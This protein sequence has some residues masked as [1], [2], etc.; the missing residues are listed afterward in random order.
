MARSLASWNADAA[1]D[2]EL[3]EAEL[4]TR[5]L[6]EFV[7]QMWPVV[8]PHRK[9]IDNW[10]IGVICEHLEAVT[11][12]EIK[13]LLIN[14][15]PRH[16]KAIR[17]DEPVWTLN[18]WTPH[19][20]LQP[21]DYVFG[22]D[23][24]PKRVR[25][26]SPAMSD[27]SYRVIF[28]T[29][30]SIVAGAG[31]EWVVERERYDRTTSW[32]RQRFPATVETCG[33]RS[34][35]RCVGQ[36]RPDRIAL[37][38]PVFGPD[39]DLLID[40]YVLGAWLGDGQKR[41]GCIGVAGTDREHFEREFGI[42]SRVQRE[43]TGTYG[44]YH[45]FTV[46]DLSTKLRV[47][48]IHNKESVPHDYLRG[49]VA[50]RLALLQGLMDTD[51]SCAADGQCLFSNTNRALVAAVMDLGYSL[52]FKMHCRESRSR[53]NGVDY[54][55]HWQITFRP[56][57]DLLPFR[58]HRKAVRVRQTRS[59]R[60]S[61]RY[62]AAV[63]PVG[64]SMVNCITVDGGVYLVGRGLIPTHNSLTVN[65]FWP[66]WTWAQRTN[67]EKPLAGPGTSFLFSTYAHDL[68]LRDSVK[69]RQVLQSD[70]YQARWGNRWRFLPDQ[71]AKHRYK[72]N[73]G[74]ERLSV[75]VGGKLTGEG[76]DI[77]VVDDP[78]NTVDIESEAQR[79]TAIEWWRQSMS[80]RLNNPALG[81]FVVIMQRLAK[82]D[83][84]G[85]LIEQGGWTHL[86]LPSLYEPDHPYKSIHDIRVKDGDMLW[87]ERITPEFLAEEELNKGSYGF[88]GQH[89]QR[90]SP[91]A[92]GMFKRENWKI[93][94]AAPA[95][96]RVVRAWDLAATEE[97]AQKKSLKA[98]FTV[99]L[100]MKRGAGLVLHRRRRALSRRAQE[101]ARN[102]EV[103]RC[104][105]RPQRHH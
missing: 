83:L 41:T 11:R 33:L 62:V 78:H 70:L 19:G 86:C 1:R 88:A 52:G 32:K 59:P 105:G 95:G 44:S 97:A 46:P 30:E 2:L 29:G 79:E 23:G 61:G 58:L 16:M 53:L 25:A 6:H 77:V 34:S 12:G 104:P 42:P 7:R 100:K 67:P 56:G 89:Q 38:R 4:A 13:R 17:F 3:I 21:D 48:G 76:G 51:G 92:G 31:H 73:Q 98:A 74:G 39:R 26:V 60:G 63:Q 45:I 69:C 84:S 55:P 28:D 96:G 80:N 103:H 93:V 37:V 18:G 50:Q 99:G 14:E 64:Q 15:P 47:L 36:N 91:R 24:L 94:E 101:G 10:H 27:P 35:D 87:P 90:P 102:D 65:V 57:S 75:S 49:S 20:E 85:Y 40:P 22:P 54:H 5:H 72:N 81:A 71:N 9:F 43:A 8:E 68:T 66:A 82:N